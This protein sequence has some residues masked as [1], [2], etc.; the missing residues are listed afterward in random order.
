MIYIV[1]KRTSI[2][3]RIRNL[4]LSQV[5]VPLY[6][7]IQAAVQFS[8]HNLNQLTTHLFIHCWNKHNSQLAIMIG[9]VIKKGFQLKKVTYVCL[10]AIYSYTYVKL[11]YTQ[12]YTT[13]DQL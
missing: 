7:L 12:Q 4:N 10:Q 1:G 11:M 2:T 8:Q 3:L 13:H 5:T 9:R 6:I